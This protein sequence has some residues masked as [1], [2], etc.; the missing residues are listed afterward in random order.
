VV[1]RELAVQPRQQI[2][3]PTEVVVAEIGPARADH[4]RRIGRSDIGPLARQ[5]GELSRV[6]VEVD[7]VLAPGLPAID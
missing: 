3:E 4:D 1:A 5:S 2:G 6:V 7:A